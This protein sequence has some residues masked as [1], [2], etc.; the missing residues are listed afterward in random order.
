MGAC[1]ILR[2]IRQI[3]SKHL[4]IIDAPFAVKLKRTLITYCYS[5]RRFVTYGLF[6]LPFLESQGLCLAPPKSFQTAGEDPQLGRDLRK[7]G[8]L[9]QFVSF[10]LFGGE[11]IVLF[12]KKRPSQLKV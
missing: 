5:V 6:C 7:F 1:I 8:W 11:G 10:G 12:L 3:T 9:R 2:S 4:A